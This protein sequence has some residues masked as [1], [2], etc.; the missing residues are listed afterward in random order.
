MFAW[1]SNPNIFVC[2]SLVCSYMFCR[3][4]C[5]GWPPKVLTEPPVGPLRKVVFQEPAVRLSSFR[6][7]FLNTQKHVAQKGCLHVSLRRLMQFHVNQE[8]SVSGACLISLAQVGAPEGRSR[9]K[10][11]PSKAIRVNGGGSMRVP[12]RGFLRITRF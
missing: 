7:L 11:S 9:G 1:D 10:R 3:H 2:F 5:D 12:T 4:E 6:S 8:C